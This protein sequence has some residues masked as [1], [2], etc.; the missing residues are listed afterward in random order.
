MSAFPIKYV[1]ISS[2][3]RRE[4]GTYGKDTRGL[5]RVHQFQKVEQVVLCEADHDQAL[6]LHYEI[7]ENAELIHLHAF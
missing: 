6:K 5:Y 4:A 2:C 7:L 3:Y 1:G